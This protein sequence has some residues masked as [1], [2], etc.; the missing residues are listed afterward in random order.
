M[1]ATRCLLTRQFLCSSEFVLMSRFVKP[2]RSHSVSRLA[3]LATLAGLT[4]CSDLSRFG[5]SLWASKRQ[6]QASNEVTGSV[7]PRAALTHTVVSH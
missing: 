3:P 6:P 4:G 7:R 2:F 5:E 1:Q